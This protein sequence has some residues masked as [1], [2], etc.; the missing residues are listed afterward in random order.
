MANKFNAKPM[1][2]D[3]HRFASRAEAKRYSE[4][5]LLERAKQITALQLQPKYP[6]N[7]GEK[8]IC[9]YIADFSYFEN[10][11]AVAEDVKGVKTKDYIIKAKL[12]KAL[13][14]DILH[15]ETR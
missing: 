15:R 7:I 2:V 9:A 13:Y 5:K 11:R 10:G 8:H 3:G 6:I 4:L 14:P 1:V 12:F